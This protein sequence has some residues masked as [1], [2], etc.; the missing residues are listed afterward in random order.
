[1]ADP[2]GRFNVAFD[3]LSNLWDVEWTALDQLHPSLVVSYTIDRGRQYELDRVDV[4]RATVTINDPEGL[5]DPTNSSSPYAE[6]FGL[7]PMLQASLARRNPH[8]A[9][10]YTRFRGFIENFEYLVDPPVNRATI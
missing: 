8:T 3:Q 9:A 5:L 2:A 10:W 4:G 1:M 7:Q 6:G